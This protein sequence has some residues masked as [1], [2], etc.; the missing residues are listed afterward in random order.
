LKYAVRYD[1]QSD[2]LDLDDFISTEVQLFV[3]VL[4]EEGCLL[5]GDDWK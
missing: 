1:I 4:K 3:A 5:F 2:T